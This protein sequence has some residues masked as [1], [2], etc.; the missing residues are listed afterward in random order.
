MR[1]LLACLIGCAAAGANAQVTSDALDR[2]AVAVRQAQRAVLIGA[3]RAGRQ[4]VAV[5]ERGLILASQDNAQTWHQRDSPVSKTLTAVR[6]VDAQHG[7]AVGHGGAVLFTGD[8]GETWTRRF[9][10][11]QAAQLALQQARAGGDARAV[12][13]A[14]RLV[15]DGADK[16]FLDLHV[17]DSQRVL[18]VGANNLAFYTADGGQSW[19]SW[20]DRLDNPQGLHL[21][22]LR[23][24]GD[25]MLIVGEQGLI[26]RSDDAGK[27]FRRLSMPYAGS[28]FTCELLDANTMVAAGL[29]GTVVYSGDAG[30]DWA[31]S[32]LP[33]Q[34]SVTGSLVAGGEIVLVLQSGAVFSAR[35]PADAAPTWRT[36]QAKPDR[37]LPP[38]NAALA[39]N[40]HKLLLLSLQGAMTLDRRTSP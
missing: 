6:F 3:A 27:R 7:V 16:P 19:Q 11:L 8:A 37:G 32:K 15:E 26:L 23:V 30:A 36:W 22:A 5:G 10:G 39:L 13:A 34:A 20:M 28:F 40:D 29:R 2:A 21:Y 12:A 1:L 4:V 14:Q 17:F 25:V 18:V 31:V 9:D 33:I 35:R 38:L 24:L